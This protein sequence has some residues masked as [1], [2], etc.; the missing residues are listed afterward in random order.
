MMEE[1]N[2]YLFRMLNLQVV[3]IE[4]FI[5]E[6]CIIFEHMRPFWTKAVD[7][8]DFTLVFPFFSNPAALEIRV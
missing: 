1:G 8:V 4:T 5:S 2:E 7:S 3:N 6:S